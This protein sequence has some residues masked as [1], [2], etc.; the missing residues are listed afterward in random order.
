AAARAHFA[1]FC[2]LGRRVQIDGPSLAAAASVARVRREVERSLEL[3]PRFV[4]AIVGKG[5]MLSALPWL[6]GGDAAEGERLLRDA[7]ALAPEHSG[8]HAELAK[9]LD[10]KG[11]VN[12]AAE[13]AALA[14]GLA[15]AAP[16]PDRRRAADR[17]ASAPTI[18]GRRGS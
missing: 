4:D 15:A 18:D 3:S 12:A 8:A 13:E 11:E 1:V 14:A 16:A 7:V 9:V 10:R 6:L 5:A 2:N 17:R